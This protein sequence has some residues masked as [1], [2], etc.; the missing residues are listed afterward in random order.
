[1][2]T[3][4]QSSV[5]A[6]NAEERF[7]FKLACA[8]A[9][10]LVGGFS[11]H[12]AAGRSSFAVPPIYHLHGLVFFGWLG[13]F[14]TQTWLVSHDNLALHR[15]LGWLSALWVPVMAVLAITITVTSLRRSGG[16]FFFDANEFLLGNIAGTVGFVGMVAAAVRMRKRTDWHRRLMIGAT[17]AITGPGWGRLLPTPLFIPY[18]WEI[19]NSI[20]MV[21]VVA[22]IVRDKRANGAV[23]PAWWVALA[24]GLGWIVVGEVLAYTSW[25]IELTQ[26]VMA[27][28][29]GAARPMEAYLP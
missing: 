26:S 14:L 21:F 29:P 11:I 1:M 23:H 28:H 7:F 16:P 8:I 13:L 6:Q 20:G 4:F 10:V 2:A 9:V 27:G 18:G 5:S 15:R 3:T 19:T 24:A 25:G 22:G 12:L 17:A